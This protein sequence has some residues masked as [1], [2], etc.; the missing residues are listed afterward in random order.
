MASEFLSV[1]RQVFERERRPLRAKQIVSLAI[2]HGLF[3]DKIAGKT[4]HQ[5][6]KSKLSVHIR[7]K[8]ENSDFVR[9]APGF[10]LLR[11]LL[12][13]GAKSYAAKPI[14]KSPS[15][16]S[17]LVFDKAWFPEDLRFQGISTSHKRLSRRLLEPHVCQ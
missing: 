17:V 10:F 1:A 2:D 14:T 16:E 15:K 9:T 8:G 11:S 13:I 7:R 6:M 3:S 4:P 12:D 5:T